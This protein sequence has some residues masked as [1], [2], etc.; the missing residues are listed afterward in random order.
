MKKELQANTW[1]H[2]GKQYYYNNINLLFQVI[3]SCTTAEL[4]CNVYD[5]TVLNQIRDTCNTMEPSRQV[6]NAGFRHPC[7]LP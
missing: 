1:H 4:F 2:E 7:L 6:V 3:Q 5:V